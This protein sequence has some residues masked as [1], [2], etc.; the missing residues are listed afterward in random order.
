MRSVVKCLWEG[1]KGLRT[2][3]YIQS[4]RVGTSATNDDEFDGPGR[5]S[6]WWNCGKLYTTFVGEVYLL[7]PICRMGQFLME[8]R[9]ATEN[10]AVEI[11]KLAM[12]QG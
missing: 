7:L 5:A 3:N 1:E 8:M 6:K 9:N 11:V 10:K 12:Q 4:L 2:R